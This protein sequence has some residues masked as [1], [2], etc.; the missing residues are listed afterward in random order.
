MHNP[1]M[2]VRDKITHTYCIAC[3]NILIKCPQMPSDIEQGLA[4]VLESLSNRLNKDRLSRCFMH[5]LLV[6]HVHVR[7]I[8]LLKY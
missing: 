1:F 4:T 2:I 5:P 3:T 8:E 6:R 7:V